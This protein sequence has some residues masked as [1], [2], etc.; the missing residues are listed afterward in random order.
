MLDPA[1][2]R[3]DDRVLL[4]GIPDFAVIAECARRLERGILVA[5]G[6]DE[7]VRQARKAAR[8]LENVMFV[9]GAPDEIPWRDG[10]FTRVIDLV[11]DWPEPERVRS[12]IARVT[13]PAP[14]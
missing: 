8:H 1:Q 14:K 9:P 4:I 12:E 3:P 11:G 6:E 7:A 10:F 5:M 13:T 2:L